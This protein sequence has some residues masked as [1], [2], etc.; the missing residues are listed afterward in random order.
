MNLEVIFMSE[1][2]NYGKVSYYLNYNV[3]NNACN[4]ENY[5]I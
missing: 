3:F 1:H 4:D 2:L 5:F